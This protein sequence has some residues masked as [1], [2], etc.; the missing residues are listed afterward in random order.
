MIELD[1]IR[2]ARGFFH[3]GTNEGYDLVTESFITLSAELQSRAVKTRDRGSASDSRS[4]YAPIAATTHFVTAKLL[5]LLARFEMID[6]MNHELSKL[7]D[8]GTHQSRIYLGLAV[9]DFHADVFTLL[10][11]LASALALVSGGL[12]TEKSRR[13]PGWTAIQLRKSGAAGAHR[14]NLAD[15]FCKLVDSTD[16]W[17]PTVTQI[18]DILTHRDRLKLIAGKPS[19]GIFFQLPGWTRTTPILESVLLDPEQPDVVDFELYSAFVIAEILAL[20]DELG[21]R[22]SRH[23]GVK[24][25]K[26]SLSMRYGDYRWSAYGM[27]RLRKLIEQ[28]AG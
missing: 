7:P 20:L 27:D 15:D 4:R 24:L 22:M 23:L 1:R 17:L 3:L 10:D 9:K 26:Q 12:D 13:L 21:Q 18:R 28:Q 14:Q 11:P 5:D 8:E 19:D 2:M 16:R 25:N 6:W